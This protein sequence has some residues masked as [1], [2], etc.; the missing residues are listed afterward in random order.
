MTTARSLFYFNDTTTTPTTQLNQ[1]PF[2]IAD[3]GKVLVARVSGTYSLEV[4][5]GTSE[6]QLTNPITWGL[7]YGAEGFTP[8]SVITGVDNF[9][10]IWAMQLDTGTA[11]ASYAPYSDTAGF[12]Q[13]VSLTH[14]WLGQLDIGENVDFYLSWGDPFSIAEGSYNVAGTL[15][16]LHT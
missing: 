14:E 11:L 15:E 12:L 1:G 3:I 7:Q 13:T 6:T 16:I 5:E 4:S 10:F 8:A 2:T 9:S